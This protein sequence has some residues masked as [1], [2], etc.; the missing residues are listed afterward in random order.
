MIDIRLATAADHD[1]IWKIFKKVI[2]NGDTYVYPADTTREALSDLWLAKPMHTYVAK[3]LDESGKSE[4]LGTYILK[5]NFPGRGSHIANASYMVLP[6]AQNRGIGAAMASHSLQ[7]AKRLGFKAMQFNLVV[8]TNKAAIHLWQKVGFRIIGTIP[9]AFDH[10]NLGYV[11]AHVM[12]RS[13]DDIHN[14][15]TESEMIK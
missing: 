14:S 7:E 6:K 4:V 15:R 13:L 10:K 8:S 5:P 3:M 9:N 12:Y 1:D 2:E 11:S